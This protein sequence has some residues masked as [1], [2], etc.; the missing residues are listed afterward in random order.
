[1]EEDK[2][3]SEKI[4][5][6]KEAH[7]KH[8]FCGHH[9]DC[10]GH[11][12]V[13]IF[14]VAIIVF[15]I[16]SIGVSFGSHLNLGDRGY[17]RESGNYG[18]KMMNNFDRRGDGQMERGNKMIGS[19]GCQMGLA[20]QNE[21]GCPMRNGGAQISGETFQAQNFSCP[22]LNQN[23]SPATPVVPVKAVAPVIPA[24]PIK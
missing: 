10:K 5:E 14:L 17:Y 12:C 21:G 3:E 24:T 4:E 22:M 6:S 1:M 13:R 23:I 15:A 16:F 7:K 20:S 11:K 19:G 2:I 9:G 18:S 8:G